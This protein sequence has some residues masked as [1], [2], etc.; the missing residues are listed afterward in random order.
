[1]SNPAQKIDPAHVTFTGS[2]PEVYD[3]YLGPYLFEFSAK[4]LA[5]RIKNKIPENGKILEIACGTGIST[6]YLRQTLPETVKITATDLNPAMLDFAKNKHGNLANVT[7]EIADALS[8]PFEKNDFDA[9]ICQFGIMFFPDKGAGLSEMARVL[10]PGG[11]M[12]FNVW[13]SM[14]N[15]KAVKIAHETIS[16]FFDSH[17]PQFLHTPFGFYDID[18]IKNLMAL[19][20]LNNIAAHILSE[21][22]EGHEAA[23]IAKG[24]VEG[25][26]GVLEIN[27]RANAS[28]EEI[29]KAVTKALEATY[30]SSPITTE[31]QALVFIAEK[32]DA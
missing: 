2:I 19:A 7:F 24:T 29:T 23:N 30:G 32:L 3:T 8:L 11:T 17:P 14:E 15:N 6:Y 4:D 12:A 27:E 20:K 31:L 25:N 9:I 26:P 21:T 22:A 5:D 13:D 10:K 1:M 16:R 28:A 18:H